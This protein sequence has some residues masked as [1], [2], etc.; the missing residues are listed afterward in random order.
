MRF[1]KPSALNPTFL[2]TLSSTCPKSQTTANKRCT[3]GV[4][5]AVRGG[6]GFLWLGILTLP[7]P[8]SEPV[9]TPH[10]EAVDSIEKSCMFWHLGIWECF[11]LEGVEG[12]KVRADM[13]KC[14]ALSIHDVD[15]RLSRCTVWKRLGAFRVKRVSF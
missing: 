6:T 1:L 10:V 9:M 13:S 7:Q 8:F 2:E 14:K 3:T 12:F 15:P 4:Q 5:L 11:G